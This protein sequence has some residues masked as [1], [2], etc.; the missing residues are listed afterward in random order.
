[1]PLSTILT[2]TQILEFNRSF[3]SYFAGG[4]EIRDITKQLKNSSDNPID[5]FFD[6]NLISHSILPEDVYRLLYFF[7]SE[8]ASC[9]FR[10]P[11]PPTEIIPNFDL[12][13]YKDRLAPIEII[14]QSK[15]ENFGCLIGINHYKNLI[16]KISIGFKDLKRH[17]Y[18]IG[19][20]G[21]GKTTVLNTMILDLIKKG[22]GVCV[23]D[24]HGDLFTNILGKIPDS[25]IND[26]V[27]IDPSDE[28]NSIALN[29]LEYQNNDEKYFIAN[30]FVGIIRKLIE[31][32]YGISGAREVTGPI[33][34]KYLRMMTLLVMSNPE[35][36]G[37]IKDLYDCFAYSDKWCEFVPADIDDEQLEVFID[38]LEKTDVTDK[39]RDALS[40]GDY[41]NSKLYNFVFDP[42][43]RRIF[44]QKKSSFNFLD[45]INSN[46]IILVNLAKGLL[47]EENSRFFGMLIMAKLT[48]AAMQRIKMKPTERNDFYLVVDEFQN[49]A[50][51]SF[52]SL[53]SEARKFG[54]SLII[55]NQFLQQI[56]D[57]QITQSI[58]GNVGTVICFRIGQMD[59][60]RIEQI[61]LPYFSAHDL[62]NLPNWF[63]YVSTTFQGKNNFPFI[64]ETIPDFTPP[65]AKTANKVRKISNKIF[66]SDNNQKS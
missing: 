2:F 62:I 53:L 16:N 60:G 17:V 15:N 1:M 57:E 13:L 11:A 47:T 56:I 26:V 36:I 40:L 4:Y 59:A 23:I 48:A 66:V 27:V 39:G 41:I 46:K 7:N 9:G 64:I 30:E 55:A 6:L 34:Y 65:S 14:E 43:L 29:F 12:K 37:N 3:D 44:N 21:T 49:V 18:I 51:T 54:F 25:R 38:E 8:E 22:K 28:N 61:F 19:Q 35:K 33:F 50:T 32:E 42:K 20:T 45:L 10:F 52:T 24:P 58:F 63:A 5:K 31:S